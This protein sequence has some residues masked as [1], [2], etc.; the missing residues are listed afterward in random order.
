MA[1]YYVLN[2][3]SSWSSSST[4]SW[5]GNTTVPIQPVAPAPPKPRSEVERLMADVESVCA[6]GRAA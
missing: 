4:I 2:S 5:T 1:D 3:G 6:L